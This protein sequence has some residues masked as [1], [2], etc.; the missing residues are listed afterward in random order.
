[1][2]TR[3]GPAG[4]VGDRF[5]EA[6]TWDSLGYAHHHLGN[7][8]QA[9]ACYRRA[10]DLF[11]AVGHRYY[12]ADTLTHIG[13]SQQAAGDPEAARH[14][15][16]GSL[17]ILDALGHPDAEQVRAKVHRPGPPPTTPSPP[18]PAGSGAGWPD[19]V[20]RPAAC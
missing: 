8:R 15:W 20:H 13:D 5:G 4:S 6:N 7:H 2:R 9:I 1:M 18:V 19:R 11:R 3:P 17:D 16:L 12:E 10:V 14:C